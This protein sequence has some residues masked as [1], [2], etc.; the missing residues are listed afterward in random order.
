MSNLLSNLCRDPVS[1]PL[2]MELQMGHH[3]HM[4]TTCVLDF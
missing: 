4:A 2:V 1:A 3:T